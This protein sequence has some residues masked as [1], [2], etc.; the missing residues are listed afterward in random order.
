MLPRPVSPSRAIGDLIG[1]IKARKRSE[2]LF[3]L[4]AVGITLLW[5]V[6]I[7][8]KLNPEPEYRA[9]PVNYAKQWPA[10]RTEA[11]VKAQQAKD[12]PGE[13]A[14]KKRLEAEAA[15]RKAQYDRLAKQ[16]GLD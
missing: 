14:E 13:I 7:F 10:T 8:D 16:F 5:F 12:L 4:L 15:A 3:G 1:F 6:M 9:P 11:D 2:V